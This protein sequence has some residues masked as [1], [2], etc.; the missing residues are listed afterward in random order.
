MDRIRKLSHVAFAVAF[1][2]VTASAVAQTTPPAFGICKP[3]AQK[4]TPGDLGCWILGEQPVGRIGQ[5][6][7][8][9]QLDVY[10]T[11]AAAE[12]AKGPHSAV[13]ESMGKIWLLT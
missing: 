2:M 5:P 13:F 10:P 3:A 11:R 9:W 8:W 12:A 6:Q 4:K 1:V 7:A